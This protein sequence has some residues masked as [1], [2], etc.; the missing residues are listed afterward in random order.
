MRVLD[1][2]SPYSLYNPSI[3]AFTM[4][5]DY[6]QKDAEGFINLLGLPIKLA[7]LTLK[8]AKKGA[9]KRSSRRKK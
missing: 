4:G 1:R 8:G 7:A 2:R 6:N 3:A 5:A 9:A